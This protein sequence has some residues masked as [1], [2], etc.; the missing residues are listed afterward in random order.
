MHFT[1]FH[2]MLMYFINI[3]KNP[4]NL[5]VFGCIPLDFVQKLDL[6]GCFENV[7]IFQVKINTIVN[8]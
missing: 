8:S 3:Y 1:V 2:Q 7:T 4:L 6:V 5:V